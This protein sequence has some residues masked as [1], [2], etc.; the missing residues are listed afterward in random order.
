MGRHVKIELTREPKDTNNAG[1]AVGI[2]GNPEVG[3]RS[4][5]FS[6]VEVEIYKPTNRR[7]R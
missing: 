3:P 4:S 2:I 1:T 6:I 7:P 5:A